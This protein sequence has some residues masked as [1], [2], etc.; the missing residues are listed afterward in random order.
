MCSLHSVLPIENKV[1]KS[2]SINLCLISPVHL[3]SIVILMLLNCFDGLMIWTFYFWHLNDVYFPSQLAAYHE[4]HQRPVRSL[5]ARGDT[6]QQEEEDPW[7]QGALLHILHTSH[8]PLVRACF[9]SR[10]QQTDP[11]FFFPSSWL[12]SCSCRRWFR[13]S[14]DSD[15]PIVS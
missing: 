1:T 7:L 10:Q 11:L 14:R 6:H 5:P 8:R 2:L 4:V 13:P 3:G 12:G 15:R 9:K